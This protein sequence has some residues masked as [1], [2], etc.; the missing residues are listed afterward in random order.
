MEDHTVYR[1]LSPD[2]VMKGTLRIPTSLAK[3][4]HLY[5]EAY[6]KTQLLPRKRFDIACFENSYPC[7]FVKYG[8]KFGEIT[9]KDQF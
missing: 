6:F 3:E 4:E 8:A 2:M 9:S 7:N 1:K 5:D